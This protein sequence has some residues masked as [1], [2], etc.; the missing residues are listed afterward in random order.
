MTDIDAT[1]TLGERTSLD[2]PTRDSIWSRVGFEIELLAPPGSS[3]K[4]LADEL[5][6]GI[7]GSVRATFHHDTEP[8]LVPGRSVFHQLTHGYE[9]VDRAGAVVCRLVDDVTIRTDLDPRLAPT[10]GLFRILSDDARLVRL[11]QNLCDPEAG[12]E[13]VLDPMAEAFGSEIVALKSGRY[14]LD[15]ANRATVAMIAPQGGERQRVC[16]IVTPPLTGDHGPALERLLEPARRLGFVVPAEAAVHIHLDADPFRSAPT[17]AR[18]VRLLSDD[19]DELWQALGTNKACRR[20]SALPT[21]LVE[22]VAD[23]GFVDRSHSETLETLKAAPLTKFSDLNLMNLRNRTPGK[24]TVEIRIL[25]GADRAAPILD[26][27]GEL[28]RRFETL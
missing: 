7:D 4:T 19:R 21:E 12:P 13:R 15:D 18:L 6:G 20:L 9:V 17:L 8:T 1:T 22:A 26:G 23:P 25:P 5:A 24:D 2:D 11:A 3:R 16:E 27:V 10:D 28:R 14:R